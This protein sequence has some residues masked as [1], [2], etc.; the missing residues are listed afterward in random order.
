MRVSVSDLAR[1]LVSVQDDVDT[2]CF[3]ARRFHVET[4]RGHRDVCLR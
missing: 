2:L 4:E 1:D 3:W